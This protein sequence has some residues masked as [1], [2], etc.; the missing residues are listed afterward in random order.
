[1]LHQVCDACVH[2]HIVSALESCL[3]SSVT[4]PQLGCRVIISPSAICDILLKYNNHNLLN[5]YLRKQDCKGSSDEWVQR[6]TLRCPSCNVPIQKNGGCNRLL[7]SRYSEASLCNG[8]EYK[9]GAKNCVGESKFD[10]WHDYIKEKIRKLREEQ[11]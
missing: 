9:C 11:I 6:F 8:L 3:I 2:Q 10:F 1:M 5:N 4:C 7:C